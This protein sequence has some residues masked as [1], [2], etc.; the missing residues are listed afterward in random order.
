MFL[1]WLRRTAWQSVVG[2]LLVGVLALQGGV[3][4]HHDILH[5]LGVQTR[6]V[7]READLLDLDALVIPGG[8]SSV[9][10][11]L[12]RTFQLREP[13]VAAIAAGLP[14]LGTCAGLILLADR[15]DGAA[16]GQQ[17]FGGIDVTVSRN[18][19]GSQ[20]DSFDAHIAVAGIAEPVEASFIRAPLVSAV[21]PGAEVIATLADGRIVG[22]RQGSLVG[23]SFHPETA[24][25]SA[26]HSWFL[27]Q[28][29]AESPAS[30]PLGR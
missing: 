13:L 2:D 6:E 8:E 5:R 21:G 7:R 22:V 27:T 4:E 28:V 17:T 24:G 25:D 29:V 11:R 26:L 18:A 14:V 23:V 12:S 9:I 16:P 19:F 30:E 1:T 3:R 15:I 20:L 10:D